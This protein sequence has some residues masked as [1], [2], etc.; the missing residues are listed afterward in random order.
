MISS[1]RAIVLA[2][3]LVVLFSQC[4]QEPVDGVAVKSGASETGQIELELL[5]VTQTGVDFNNALNDEGHINIFIWNFMYSGAGIAI[6]D[7]NN[8]GLPDLYFGGNQVPDRLYLNKG[9][10]QFEDISE[11][12]GIQDQYWTTGVTMADVNADGLLD[13]YVCRNSPTTNYTVNK[14]KLFINKGDLTFTEEAERYGIDDSG[15]SIQASFFD[16]DLDGDLDM[17]LLNQPFDEFA[18]LVNEPGQV[19]QYPVTDRLF[20]FD[21]D[22]FMD[23]TVAQGMNNARYGLGI[24]LADVDLNG[25][26]D[27]Y[28]CN[29]YHQADHLYMNRVNG[30]NDE[31]L[32]RVGHISFYAMGC[33]AGD[34]NSDGWADVV[35]LDMAFADHLRSKTNMASM[36]TDWFAEL[37]AEGQHYQYMQNTLQINRGGYFSEIAQVAGV[38]KTDWSWASLF[39]DLDL[40]GKQD[41]LVTNGIMRDIKNN[42]FREF[43]TNNYGGQVGPHNFLQVLAQMPSTPVSNK[44]YR[45]GEDLEFLDETESSGFD[46]EGFSHGMAYAD[47]DNDGDLDFVVNNMGLPASV[48][49]NNTQ[50]NGAYLKI[51]I[52]GPGSNRNGLGISARVHCGTEVHAVTMQTSRGYLSSGEPELYVGLGSVN[53]VDSVVISWNEKAQSV[54]RNV[55]VNSTLNVNFSAVD[56][57][58]REPVELPGVKME[59]SGLISHAHIERPF[60]DYADQV[61]LPYKLSENGP[62]TA[63]ADVNGDG[64]IDLYVGGSAGEPGALFIQGTAGFERTDAPAFNTDARYEDGESVF[65]DFDRDGDQDLYVVSGS[66]EFAEG[67]E[68]LTDRLYV[69]NGSGIFARNSTA[70]PETLSVNGHCIELLDVDSDGDLDIFLGGRLVNGKY[71]EPARSALLRNDNGRFEDISSSSATCLLELGLVTD[72]V[73]TDVDDDGD[74]DILVVGEWMTPTVLLNDGVR[75]TCHEISSAGAGLWWSIGVGDFDAD[76]DDDYILGNLGWNSTLR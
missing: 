24:A 67:S 32:N 55:A 3:A 75:L 9:N 66:N 68:L 62:R 31:L 54:F 57:V 15:L 56:K 41:L 59:D 46:L 26:P 74:T 36:N 27:V 60:D 42:D 2:I 70:L 7:V 22:R 47:L 71:P 39:A 10:F 19:Q 28:L 5:S 72:A 37:I 29:D 58:P 23:R 50:T 45:Q 51:R 69:N 43:V 21:G 18:R 11:R 76:G 16:A 48:Y 35:A 40:D 64:L 61:L 12:A 44:L 8:D 34:I 33:D 38:H 4:G 13:I 1:V 25:R 20:L 49:R 14:N 53:A 63:K 73:S 30:F 6:G 17:Y 52:Q 65:A